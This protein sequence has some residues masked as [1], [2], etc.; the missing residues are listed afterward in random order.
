MVYVVVIIDHSTIIGLILFRKTD[1]YGRSNFQTT[2]PAYVH[3]DIFCQPK[4]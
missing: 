3:I 2:F 1:E 4:Q